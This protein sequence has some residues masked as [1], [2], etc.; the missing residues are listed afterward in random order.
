MET[1]VSFVCAR[2]K[3]IGSYKKKKFPT[4]EYRNSFFGQSEIYETRKVFVQKGMSDTQIDIKQLGF[5]LQKEITRLNSEGYRVENIQPVISG[6]YRYD[7]GV[8]G[9][10]GGYGYGYGYS[11]TEGFLI[12]ASKAA[13]FS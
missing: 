10:D 7:K 1:I 2:F 4:G 5:D 9:V 11:Y 3:P 12:V 13:T 6:K 8:M